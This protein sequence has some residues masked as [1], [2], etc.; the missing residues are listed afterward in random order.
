MLATHNTSITTS[1]PSLP[2]TIN[3]DVKTAL[4]N[5]NDINSVYTLN[6][7][8]LR[9][10]ANDKFLSIFNSTNTIF[11]INP[12][13]KDSTYKAGDRILYN[14]NTSYSNNPLDKFLI[15][16]SLKNNNT[17]IPNESNILAYGSTDSDATKYWQADM[18]YPDVNA[19]TENPDT[20]AFI[21]RGP[22]ADRYVTPLSS[23]IKINTINTKTE[24]IESND[25]VIK[26][27]YTKL[28]CVI[29]ASSTNWIKDGMLDP[30]TTVKNN[31]Y[32]WYRIYK[33]GYV[34][35][36]GITRPFSLTEQW[37]GD[38]AK[39]LIK[40]SFPVNINC[41]NVNYNFMGCKNNFITMYDSRYS[42]DALAMYPITEG[43]QSPKNYVYKSI[44][45]TPDANVGNFIQHVDNESFVIQLNHETYDLDNGVIGKTDAAVTKITW[46]A[47]G[48]L[49]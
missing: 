41:I 35:C 39:D 19:L 40:I 15:L 46:T 5:L 26:T 9:L 20:S 7:S 25:Y 8:F 13:I 1:T 24:I 16:K 49:V 42:T 36:G 12:F 43:R 44:P 22:V 10:L 14:T 47:S 38:F 3:D 23:Y 34:E 6:K 45:K 33:S 4:M 48:I 32:S 17:I 31:C 2:Y 21:K 18:Y 28:P 27:G 29:Y 11:T 30:S 37:N